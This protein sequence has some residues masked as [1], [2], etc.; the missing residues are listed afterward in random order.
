MEQLRLRDHVVLVSQNEIRL[1]DLKAGQVIMQPAEVSD[2]RELVGTVWKMT[3]LPAMPAQMPSGAGIF[4]AHTSNGVVELRR[5]EDVNG[6]SGFKFP[7]GECD[8]VIDAIDLGLNKLK[9]LFA[10]RPQPR[11]TG[12]FTPGAHYNDDVFDGRS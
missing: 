6:N 7:V 4:T 5:T 3:S 2:L 11:S 10:L 12:A 9:D 8:F 1:R